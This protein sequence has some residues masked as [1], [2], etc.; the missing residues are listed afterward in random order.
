[1]RCT[2][3]LMNANERI[4]SFSYN[5]DSYYNGLIL[6]CQHFKQYTNVECLNLVTTAPFEKRVMSADELHIMFQKLNSIWPDRYIERQGTNN[7][8]LS[9]FDENVLLIVFG[10][11]IPE[12]IKF[13]YTGLNNKVYGWIDKQKGTSLKK[14]AIAKDYD[15][16]KKELKKLH[17]MFFDVADWCVNVKGSSSDNDIIGYTID[18]TLFE[19][20]KQSKA[21]IVASNGNANNYLNKV[22]GFRSSLYSLM[23]YAKEAPWA[24]LINEVLK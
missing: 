21:T 3:Y 8:S 10:S 11:A 12:N 6:A 2:F 24:N 5:G 18:A 20:V 1:M 19:R 13:F 9:Y 7:E 22:L 14:L 15:S 4:Y 17:L 23:S 16:L